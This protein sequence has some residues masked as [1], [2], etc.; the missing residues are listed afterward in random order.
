[1]SVKIKDWRG[2]EIHV[3]DHVVYPSR[4]SSSMWMV[5][6]EVIELIPGNL[7]PEHYYDRVPHGL[8]VRRLRESLPGKIQPKEVRVQADRVTVAASRGHFGHVHM[9]LD[10][11]NIEIDGRAS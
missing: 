8:K 4:H 10:P 11:T 2:V 7:D 3:G 1:M 5:E 6:A 9:A